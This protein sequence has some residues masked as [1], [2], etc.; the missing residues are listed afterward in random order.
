MNIWKKI[1][2][3]LESNHC[4]YLLT[5][6][7]SK[8]S[9]PGRVG[10]KMVVADNAELFGSIGGGIM[11][12]NLVEKA[13]S[14]LV[15]GITKQPLIEQ[16]HKGGTSV[17]SGMICSGSQII[18]FNYLTR[19]DLLIVS[20][21]TQ[22]PQMLEYSPKGIKPIA[23]DEKPCF[24]MK[25]A[26]VWC[27][28]ELTSI[29]PKVHIFG[30]GHVSLPTSELLMKMG[31]NVFLYDNRNNLNTFDDNT[32]VSAKTILDY[33]DVLSQLTIDRND[34]VLLMTHKF[35]EDKLL[36]FQLLDIQVNYLGVLGSHNK[37][38]V[39]FK[40]L[41]KKGATQ[42]QLDKVHAPIGLD[43]NSQTTQEIA[44]SIVAEMIKEKNSV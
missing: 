9:A 43:I 40:D 20:S 5:V 34:Y 35:T 11:E 2:L 13:K 37:I 6:V 31:F 26:D 17:S 44:V 10:F 42:S 38:S 39:M 21:C 30:A 7:E 15:A 36:L 1:Q 29:K 3:L 19:D 41:L 8:G 24:L 27:Y 12:Y 25:F 23:L 28:R 4:M 22:S 18:A 33:R 16:V 14:L 32:C